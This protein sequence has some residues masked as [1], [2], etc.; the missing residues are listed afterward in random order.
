MSNCEKE[1][2]LA[3]EGFGEYFFGSDPSLNDWNTVFLE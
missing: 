2:N 1:L 3:D